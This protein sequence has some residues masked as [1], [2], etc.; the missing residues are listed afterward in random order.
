MRTLLLI[1]AAACCLLS[2]KKSEPIAPGLFGKWELRRSYGGFSYRDSTFK[3]G[4]GTN[5]QFN[6]DSTYQHYTKNKQD[7]QG[8]FSVRTQNYSPGKP[9]Q[10]IVFNNNM[11]GELLTTDGTKLTLGTAASDGIAI[12]YEKIKN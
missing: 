1:I 9:Y 11:P 6:R 12:E 7:G 2:C 5:Y 10:Q 3:P 4:N 8:T